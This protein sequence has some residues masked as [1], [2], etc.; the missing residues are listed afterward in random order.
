MKPIVKLAVVGLLAAG[1][2][3]QT[4]CIIRRE[5]LREPA[6]A[7]RGAS[8][9]AVELEG[10]TSAEVDLRMGAGELKVKGGAGGGTLVDGDFDYSPASLRPIFEPSSSGM[11]RKVVIRTERMDGLGDFGWL[12]GARMRNAWDLRLSQDVPIA[13]S[14]NLGAGEGDIDLRDVDIEQFDLMM[15]AGDVTIDL[16]GDRNRSFDGAIQ[17]G[18]GELTIRVPKD[19][20]V[21]VRGRQDGVGEWNTPGFSADGNY[22]VNDEYESA[23]TKIDLDVQRG[24]G[25]VTLELVD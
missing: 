17:A 24:L 15:G 6:K 11:R 5:R 8:E 2:L 18:A 13:L 25:E 10:A 16:S 14:I 3:T 4:G 23:T 20:G 7:T 12:G 22:F 9:E 21:R 1:L 19:V